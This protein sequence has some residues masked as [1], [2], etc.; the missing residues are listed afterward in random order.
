MMPKRALLVLAVLTTVAT[1]CGIPTQNGARRIDAADVPFELLEPSNVGSELPA[2]TSIAP[3]ATQV[4]YLV[5]GDR[6]VAAPRPAGATDAA[7]LLQ[8]LLDGPSAQE[9]DDGTR[10]ALVPPENVLS[11]ETQGNLATVDLAPTFADT[12]AAEQRLALAQLAF[13]LTELPGIVEVAFTLAGQ[14][15]SVPR[16]DGT[17]ADGPV[18]RTDYIA[19]A[20][21]S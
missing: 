17:T 16:G 8:L 18:R 19:L 7:A 11:V 20:P 3:S 10:T 4:V 14:P 2:T 9:T 1:G 5:S 12:P 15:T 13:T 21:V 6:L